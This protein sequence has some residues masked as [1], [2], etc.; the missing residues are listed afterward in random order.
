MP[1]KTVYLYMQKYIIIIKI[2]IE[3]HDLICTIHPL[4]SVKIS[5]K[6]KYC[7]FI[8]RKEKSMINGTLHSE[9]R[10]AKNVDL[11]LYQ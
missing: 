7:T 2:L 10:I 4:N 3:I 11:F 5:E 6:V 8:D 1:V 9:V